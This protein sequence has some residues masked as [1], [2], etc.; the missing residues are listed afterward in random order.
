MYLEKPTVPLPVFSSLLRSKLM[1]LGDEVK[2]GEVIERK[3][4][5]QNLATLGYDAYSHIGDHVLF[6]S[7]YLF[8]LQ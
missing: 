4:E 6:F 8:V 5:E 7:S 3:F 2:I 1:Y